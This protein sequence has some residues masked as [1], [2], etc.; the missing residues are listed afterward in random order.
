MGIFRIFK[1]KSLSKK[2]KRNDIL[3]ENDSISYLYVSDR[4]LF[5]KEFDAL[6]RKAKSKIPNTELHDLPHI[7]EAPDVPDWYVFEHEIWGI[8]EEIRQLTL[9]YKKTFSKEQLERIIDICLDKRV[10]RGRQSFVMLLGKKAYCDYAD[11][12]IHLIEDED[13]DGH[14]ID[15]LY[16][17]QAGQYVNLITPFAE[18][19][20]TWIKNEAK[21]YIK[22]YK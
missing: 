7:K 8:G 20:I 9:K 19:K 3:N 18:H 17:M 1:K 15:T 12:I 16:K 11:S 6:L 14:V 13:V 2:I 22:K 4:E 10:K 5:D 21:R